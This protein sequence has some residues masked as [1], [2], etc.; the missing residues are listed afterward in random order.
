M[1]ADDLS[2]PAESQFNVSGTTQLPSN[3]PRRQWNWALTGYLVIAFG[4][5]AIVSTLVHNELDDDHNRNLADRI[6][7]SSTIEGPQTSSEEA[8]SPRGEPEVTTTLAEPGVPKEPACPPERGAAEPVRSFTGSPPMCIDPSRTYVATVETNR[9]DFEITL[10]ADAAPQVV[11]NFVFLAR[12]RFY[13]G[14]GFHR[15]EPGFIMDTGDPIGRP[16]PGRGGPGYTLR[17]PPPG[18]GAPPYQA[19]AVTTVLTADGATNGSQFSI[20]T[21]EVAAQTLNGLAPELKPTVFGRVTSGQEVIQE[22]DATGD[23][24]T[25]SPMAPTEIRSITIDEQ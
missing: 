8:A 14:A 17:L 6:P 18:A 12:W 13:E 19:L 15:V 10:D 20:V 11:N 24:L 16:Y 3:Q 2:K 23:E 5:G 7:T 9:G 1:T 4:A 25:G 22:I 21:G